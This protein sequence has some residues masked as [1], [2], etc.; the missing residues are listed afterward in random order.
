MCLL[1]LIFLTNMVLPQ[2]KVSVFILYPHFQHLYT[3]NTVLFFEQILRNK[4]SLFLKYIFTHFKNKYSYIIDQYNDL[5]MK[6][7]STVVTETSTSIILPHI[8][9]IFKLEEC[10]LFEL[11]SFAKYSIFKCRKDDSIYA[12]IFILDGLNVTKIC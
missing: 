4:K 2:H 10:T 12:N 1:Y 6:G 7:T 3:Y 9:N 5:I 11:D 8:N